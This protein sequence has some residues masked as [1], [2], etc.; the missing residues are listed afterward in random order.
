MP[1]ERYLIRSEELVSEGPWAKSCNGAGNHEAAMTRLRK[2][3]A[4]RAPHE[5]SP[6]H[7][8]CF[9]LGWHER[10]CLE[11]LRSLLYLDLPFPGDQ[12]P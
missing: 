10:Y 5:P 6:R 4:D 9:G 7:V 12:C 2:I 8:V 11:K 1:G 3:V